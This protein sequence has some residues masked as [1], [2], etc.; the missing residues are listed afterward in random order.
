MNLTVDATTTLKI[1]GS[2]I[3][4][5]KQPVDITDARQAL[6]DLTLTCKNP[7]VINKFMIAIGFS[8]LE[9]KSETSGDSII[10]LRNA[11]RA[12]LGFGKPIET[13]RSHAFIA[14]LPGAKPN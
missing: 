6:N 14:T 3:P 9:G 1:A 13:D 5:V 11:I 12:E 2:Q 8:N 10:D 7:D 4:V